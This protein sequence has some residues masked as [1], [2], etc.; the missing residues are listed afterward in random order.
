MDRGEVSA[1]NCCPEVPLSTKMCLHHLAPFPS[2]SI[3]FLQLSLSFPLEHLGL[4]QVSL[5]G[6]RGR[7]SETRA[8]FLRRQA[9]EREDR[10]RSWAMSGTR[11]R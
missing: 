1:V 10:E 4:G 11:C 5:A 3:P 8:E 9:R 2:L 7:R 6:A